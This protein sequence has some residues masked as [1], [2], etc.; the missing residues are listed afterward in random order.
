MI[1][2][3]TTIECLSGHAFLLGEHLVVTMPPILDAD[4]RL[5]RLVSNWTF[6]FISNIRKER[7]VMT[8]KRSGK[9]EVL[10]RTIEDFV[11]L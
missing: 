1:G 9:H 6:F 8:G 3:D 11:L 4:L 7:L 10:C 2:L 5:E